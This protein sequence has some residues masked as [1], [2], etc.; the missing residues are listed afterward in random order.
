MNG[1]GPPDLTNMGGFDFSALHDVLNVS[2][3]LE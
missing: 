1:N 2:P 3:V